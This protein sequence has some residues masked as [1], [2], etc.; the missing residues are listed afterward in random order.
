ICI[1]LSTAD[2]G[3][4]GGA[5]GDSGKISLERMTVMQATDDSQIAGTI[6]HEL[7]HVALNH[8]LVVKHV[9]GQK[10][11]FSNGIGPDR[12]FDFLQKSE[13]YRREKATLDRLVQRLGAIESEVGELEG[14][15]KALVKSA[16]PAEL[17]VQA[18]AGPE[19]AKKAIEFLKSCDSYDCRRL[20]ANSD[21]SSKLNLEI[22]RLKENEIP[23]QQ[24][25]IY[26]VAGEALP[27]DVFITWT[28]RE[29]DEAG[30]E[31]CVRAGFDPQGFI[32]R[33]EKRLWASDG[34]DSPAGCRSALE[35]ALSNSANAKDPH[36]RVVEI[37]LIEQGQRDPHPQN[38][39]RV[40]NL[41]RELTIHS[42]EYSPFLKNLRFALSGQL[43][44]A[45]SEIR[46]LGYNK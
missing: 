9:S 15:I 39:W 42:N 31:F 17:L 3:I 23:L 35:A 16:I 25:K 44:K 26:K 40:F 5:F 11:D 8:Q 32:S 29:A 14:E 36:G 1:E 22:F 20:K 10:L 19:G 45:Q 18:N 38:C 4:G 13:T 7:A 34:L 43:E 27:Q 24:Y 12:Y 41:Q 46:A 6:C 21:R 37:P 33:M 30:L 28:E 2:I